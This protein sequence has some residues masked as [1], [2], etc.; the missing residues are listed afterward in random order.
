MK[1]PKA[2]KSFD[3]ERMR[4]TLGIGKKELAGKTTQA[5]MDELRG[6]SE[7]RQKRESR[8]RR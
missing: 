1:A 7:F 5:W 6:P 2:R 4:S 8:R 3:P